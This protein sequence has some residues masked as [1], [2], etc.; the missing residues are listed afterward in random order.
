ML[1]AAETTT[2]LDVLST[3]ILAVSG[4]IIAVALPMRSLYKRKLKQDYKMQSRRLK[5]DEKEGKAK[6]KL[7]KTQAQ[8][9]HK[10]KI[11]ELNN[12]KKLKEMDIQH[13]ERLEGIV[14]EEP[15]IDVAKKAVGNTLKAVG[16]VV[17]APVRISTNA[18]QRVS[19]TVPDEESGIDWQIF[20]SKASRLGCTEKMSTTE[21]AE[22]IVKYAPEAS[23]RQLPANMPVEEKAARLV[24]AFTE[25]GNKK[26]EEN[27]R[28][29]NK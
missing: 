18:G 12:Q 29:E 6:I 21:M 25:S 22:I 1:L 8:L 14:H 15:K 16:T 20:R 3:L 11:D 24:G 23:L 10:Q 28:P 19:H 9:A 2:F 5:M 17:G 26:K 13:Q 7:E 4:I 27:Q